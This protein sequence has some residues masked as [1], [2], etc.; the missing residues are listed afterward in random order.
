VSKGAENQ[1]EAAVRLRRATR[2]IRPKPA[3][4]LVPIAPARLQ[5]KA[6]CGDHFFHTVMKEGLI[7][8]S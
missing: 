7:L 2:D 1:I 3:F 4:T 5:E 6:H 8:A